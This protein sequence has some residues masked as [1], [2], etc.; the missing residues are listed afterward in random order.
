[1]MKISYFFG[2]FPL[3]IHYCF[4]CSVAKL[5]PKL[6]NCMDCSMPGSPVLQ[7]LLESDSCSLCWWCYLTISFSATPFSFCLQSFPASESS[8]ESALRLR[9]PKYWSFGFSISPS[10]GYSGLITFRIDWFD[11]LAVQG[12]LKSLFQHHSSKAS[13][14]WHSA[15]FMVQLSHSYLTPGK[16][17]ALTLWT[18]VGKLV[19]LVFQSVVVYVCH[20]FPSMEQV[21]FNF[22]AA[23]TFH[24]DIC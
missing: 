18:F 21:S 13:T 24:D 20:S 2:S 23:V 5:C 9:W 1:M 8:S 15:F 22:M 4:H 7:Y 11:F 16:T 6:C 3:Y 12:T 17:I 10:N 14:L 19:S